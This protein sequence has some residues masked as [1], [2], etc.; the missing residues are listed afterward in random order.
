[1][2]MAL[3]PK[4]KKEPAIRPVVKPVKTSSSDFSRF[5][6]SFSANRCGALAKHNV[7]TNP[8]ERLK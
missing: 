7:V 6:I 3:I 5:A 2:V 4:D 8:F 1:M